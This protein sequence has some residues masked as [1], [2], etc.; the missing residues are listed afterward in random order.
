M[1]PPQSAFAQG[2]LLNAFRTHYQRFQTAVTNLV[3]RHNSDVI[4]ISRLGD[5]L[6]EFAAI[7]SAAS[8][9]LSIKNNTENSPQNSNIFE[10]EE[11]RTLQTSLTAMQ[12]D[13][14]LEYDDAV[15]ESHHGRPVIVQTV[16]SDGPGRP[17][18][19]IDPD[20]LR[21]AYS[22]RSTAAISRFLSVSRSTVRNALLEAGIAQPQPRLFP[23]ASTS[24]ARDLGDNNADGPDDILDPELPI[25][26][27]FP[28][29]VGNLAAQS[30][31]TV[32][33]TGPLSSIS[34]DDL[35][36]LL[37]RLWTHYRRAGLHMLDGMLRRLGHHIPVERVR[38]SLL[39]INP[40]WR[41]FERIRIRRREYRVL[42]P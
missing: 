22:Q 30:H 34:D 3:E 27:A 7:V 14:R 13:I 26:S 32:S 6:D 36:E 11:F 35:D 41:I 4:V 25:P 16:P 12:N 42:G 21:W 1:D 10:A 5:D 8:A 29:D 33:Y 15:N 23:H 40:I 20:F 38:Q 37:F 24:S 2:V 17:R 19:Y 18:I 9:L 31:P 28:P 39:R